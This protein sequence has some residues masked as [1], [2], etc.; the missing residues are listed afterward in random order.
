MKT[1]LYAKYAT[2]AYLKTRSKDDPEMS[3]KRKD[4]VYGGVGVVFKPD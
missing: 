2:S 1:E 3:Q 4:I